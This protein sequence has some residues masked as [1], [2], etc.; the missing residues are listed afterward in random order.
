MNV[1]QLKATWQA[2]NEDKAQRLAASIAY[3]TIFSIAPLLI[4][5]VAIVGG[6]LNMRGHGGHTSTLNALLG[7]IRHSA[8]PGAADT[9]KALIEASFNK[10]KQG[11]IAQIL[12][13]IFFFVGASGLFAALQDALNAIWHVEAA[14]GGWKHM[15]RDR[16][17]SFGMIV[18]VGFLMLVTFL[19]NATISF[20]SAHFLGAIPF[21]ANP[22]VLSS[23]DQIISVAV[24]TV[25]F[26]LLY[27]ILP[28]VHIAWNDVWIGAAFTAVLFVIGEALIGLYIA[29]GGVASAYGAAGSLLVALIWIYY[30]AMILLLGAEFT[31]V[32][33][34]NATLTVP[35]TIR[36]TSDQPAGV[37][38]RKAAAAATTGEPDPAPRDPVPARPADA[39]AIRAAIEATRERLAGTAEA[40]AYKV[41]VPSRLKHDVAHRVDAVKNALGVPHDGA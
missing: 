39:T 13:W 22:I 21:A 40:L 20:V 37:D 2:F 31:K 27:K 11:L 4:L 34:T 17:A 1:A 28:D 12:G 24:I 32:H 16:I 8:G 19:A 5:V 10:P 3:S 14:K 15:V 9:V 6:V 38:P 23:I 35:A 18:V 30:S 41:D 36:H 33:A 29:H 26:A 25:I 7:A